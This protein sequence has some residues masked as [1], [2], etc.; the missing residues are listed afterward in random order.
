MNLKRLLALVVAVFL[1]VGLAG[2]G[3]GTADNGITQDAATSQADS[4]DLAVNAEELSRA[5]Y[6]DD[7]AASAKY[8]GRRLAVTGAFG[9]IEML[10][11][12]I[13]LRFDGTDE[14]DVDCVFPT[15]EALSTLQALQPGQTITVVGTCAGRFTVNIILNDCV[16]TDG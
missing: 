4:V 1:M 15:H 14:Y 16:L 7:L 9:K 12:E 11:D 13:R 2:C 5:Y 10:S 3:G 6:N 8:A